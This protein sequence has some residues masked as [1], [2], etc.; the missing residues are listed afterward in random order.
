MKKIIIIIIIILHI[1]FFVVVET[2]NNVKP[3]NKRTKA[4]RRKK[5]Y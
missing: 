5:R 1:K 3:H 2:Y 4:K